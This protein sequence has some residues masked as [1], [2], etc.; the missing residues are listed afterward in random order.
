MTKRN[1]YRLRMLD[2]AYQYIVDYADLNN[3]DYPAYALEQIIREHRAWSKMNFSLEYLTE[4]VTERVNNSVQANLKNTISNEINRVR[5]GTNNVDRNTQILI[6][7][8]QAL[9]QFNNIQAIMTTDQY[10]PE[11]LKSAKKAVN[12][13]IIHQKQLK[14]SRTKGEVLK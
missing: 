4:A 5:L 2:E 11:F 10:E 13:K 14:D 12:D 9:M 1:Q 8:V 3:L 7:L 6:E